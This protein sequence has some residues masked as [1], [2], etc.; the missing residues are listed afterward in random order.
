MRILWVTNEPCGA[1]RRLDGDRIESGGWLDAA[2]NGIRNAA[3]VE[4]I[5]AT[6]SRVKAMRTIEEHNVTYCLLP[7]GYPIEYDH[8]DTGN[9]R[10]WEFMKEKYRPDILQI[11]G[12]EFTHG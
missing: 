8:A 5:I 6:T 12:T 10:S 4:L 1:L 2:L 3:G 9:R 11:W 7:G